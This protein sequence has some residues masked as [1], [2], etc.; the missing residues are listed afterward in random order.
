MIKKLTVV[1][2]EEES[3]TAAS[4]RALILACK[5]TKCWWDVPGTAWYVVKE[6]KTGGPLWEPRAVGVQVIR[7]LTSTAPP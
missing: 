6:K 2:E 3:P 1:G 7:P 5:E 4:S